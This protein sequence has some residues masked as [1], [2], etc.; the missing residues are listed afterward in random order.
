T[1]HSGGDVSRLRR[2]LRG[3][4]W[5]MLRPLL[6][7]AR[8]LIAVSEFEAS[9]FRERLRL[10][11]ERFVVIPNGAYLPEVMEPPVDTTGEVEDAPLIVSIGRLERYKGHQRLIAALP[12]VLEQVPDARVRIVGAGSYGPAL[13]K[14]ARKLGVAESVEIR[15]VPPEDRRGMAAVIVRANLVTLLSDYESQGIA[16]IEALALRRPVLVAGNSGLQEFADR[17]LARAISLKSTPEEVAM[18]MV[19]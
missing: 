17:G 4:Q 16:V 2:A 3:I 7:R 19:S 15:A 14:M 5:A 6:S 8:K 10:P 9:F 13:Q 11:T 12:K 1:F 18:A